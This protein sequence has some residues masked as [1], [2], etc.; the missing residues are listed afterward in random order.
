MPGHCKRRQPHSR[1]ARPTDLDYIDC[2][3]GPRKTSGPDV[4][5]GVF[6]EDAM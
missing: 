5:S 6:A 2:G 1:L 4:T 3:H